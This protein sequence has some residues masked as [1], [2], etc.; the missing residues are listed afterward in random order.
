MKVIWNLFGFIVDTLRSSSKSGIL[1]DTSY[2]TLLSVLW[3]Y[4]HN[5]VMNF[6]HYETEM[7]TINH[8]KI[9]KQSRSLHH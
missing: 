6:V 2:A 5:T 8:M 9:A 7:E 3:F 1:T 4:G